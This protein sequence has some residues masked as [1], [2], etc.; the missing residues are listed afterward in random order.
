MIM[1]FY[2]SSN[3]LQ[4]IPCRTLS[5]A[6]VYAKNLYK[7]GKGGIKVCEIEENILYIPTVEDL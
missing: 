1:V 4:C 3:N 2:K 7:K 6:K 5:E